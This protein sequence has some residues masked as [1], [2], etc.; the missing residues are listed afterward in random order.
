MPDLLFLLNSLTDAEGKILIPGLSDQVAPLTPEE[1]EMY[2]SISFDADEFRTDAGVFQLR[3]ASD[4]V[5]THHLYVTL[6]V[7]GY[8]IIFL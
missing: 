5:C 7:T 3:H 1:E 6:S 2:N 4:A 8:W